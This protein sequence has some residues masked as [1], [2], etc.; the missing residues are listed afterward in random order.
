MGGGVK[1]DEG[2][3]T[4]AEVACTVNG[5]LTGFTVTATGS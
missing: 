4:F 2:G 5:V 1:T 3:K